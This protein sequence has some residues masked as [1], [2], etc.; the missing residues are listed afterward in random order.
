M[1]DAPAPAI[2][3]ASTDFALPERCGASTANELVAVGRALAPG[4]RM[5]V[6]A[7]AVARMSCATAVALISLARTVAETGGAVIIR[8][9]TGAF[10]DAFADLG[11]FEPLM[12]MQFAE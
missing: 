1:S 9:P 4:V 8:A 10:T 2:A 12:N 6:D 3:S 5:Q 7:S 11:L